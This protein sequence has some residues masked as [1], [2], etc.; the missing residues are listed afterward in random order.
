M[1]AALAG[2]A[3]AAVWAATEPAWQRV[4]RTDYSDIRLV[5]LPLHLV[6]GAVFGLVWQRFEIGGVRAAL[7][8]H[9]ALW[10]LLAFID[11][12]AAKDPRAFASS[13][14]GHAVFGFVLEHSG[15]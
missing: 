15:R 11:R 10:P 14:A 5:G 2:V 13:A 7:L 4:F 8:E 3:A 12:D 6:N 9:V 1:R